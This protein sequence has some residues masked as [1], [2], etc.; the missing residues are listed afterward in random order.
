[1][2]RNT[3]VSLLAV[4]LLSIFSYSVLFQ[5][6]FYY[7]MDDIQVRR[8]DETRREMKN[9]TF[10]IRWISGLSHDFGYPL[11]NFYS[12]LPYYIGGLVS[13]INGKDSVGAAKVTIIL[14]FILSTVFMFLL[15]KELFGNVGG[16]VTSLF[17]NYSPFHSVEIYVRGSLTEFWAF[18]PI[19]ILLYSLIKIFKEG[20]IINIILASVSF[21]VLVLTHHVVAILFSPILLAIIYYLHRSKVGKMDNL[22]LAVLSI[23]LGLGLSAFFWLP[24]FVESS[25]VRATMLESLIYQ[26]YKLYF[27]PIVN[28]INSPWGYEGFSL[29]EKGAMS[30]EIGKIHLLV[31]II[32][33][34]L[35]IKNIKSKISKLM[36][37][38]L[39]CLLL[40]VFMVTPYSQKIWETIP[41]FI[42]T[43]YPWRYLAITS[44]F[45]SVFSGYLIFV[46]KDRKQ[47]IISAAVLIAALFVLEG[48]KF[49][50]EK[51]EPNYSPQVYDVYDTTTW[52]Y[53]YLPIWIE[54]PVEKEAT[55]KI[56]V[57][58]SSAETK[59]INPRATNYIFE[60]NAKGFSRIRFNNY[61]FPGWNLYIDGK[62]TVID[63]H[64]PQGLITFVIPPGNHKINIKFEDTPIRKVGNILS[65]GSAS[66][67]LWIG[68]KRKNY[69]KIF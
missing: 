23:G 17:Y 14:G 2:T 6:G 5:K 16:I 19:P 67:I 66:A 22:K 53:Q 61:Y 63:F 56:E 26:S 28:L 11:F 21:S 4:M 33:L 48:Y 46:L 38:F 31:I 64:N 62:L 47:K 27:L 29:T 51:M 18:V 59:V 52:E 39:F 44:F 41:Y 10:P 34:P 60:A 30:F 9:L 24:S 58:T 57:L 32:S 54:K 3:F 13:A 1:M 55:T 15:G 69:E 42:Y 8:I 43:H 40:S 50:P 36:A 65:L 25:L 12:P 35:V 45:S 68:F 7:A 37:F 49:K 20:K